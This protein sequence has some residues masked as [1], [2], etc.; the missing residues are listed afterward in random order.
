MRPRHVAWCCIFGYEVLA[1]R[2]QELL[3]EAVDDWIAAHPYLTRIVI[4]YTA[5]HLANH[6]PPWADG[7]YLLAKLASRR[8]VEAVT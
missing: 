6:L 2:R 4:Y 3:S 5:L 1:A 8:V 7:F